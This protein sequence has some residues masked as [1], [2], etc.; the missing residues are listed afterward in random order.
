MLAPP[1][2]N[3]RPPFKVDDI[4]YNAVRNLGEQPELVELLTIAKVEVELKEEGAVS[5]WTQFWCLIRVNTN[6]AV[7]AGAS[8]YYRSLS[9]KK[10]DNNFHFHAALLV[11][12]MK[13]S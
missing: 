2:E 12:N 5:W 1:F 8:M 11:S 9:R 4:K 13:I 3:F 6:W 10:Q 7:V